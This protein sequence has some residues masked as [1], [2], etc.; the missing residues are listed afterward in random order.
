M[1]LWVYRKQQATVALLKHISVE[2]WVMAGMLIAVTVLYRLQL[3][4]DETRYVSVAWEMWQHHQWLLPTLNGAPYADK[5]PLL[6]WLINVAWGLF[7]VH[8]WVARMVIPLIGLIN[9]YLVR[10]IALFFWP[11]S[12]SY[13]VA[14]LILISM[15]GWALYLPMTMFDILLSACVLAHLLSWL[16][17]L[18]T[19]RLSWVIAAGLFGG[20]GILTK[21]PVMLLDSLVVFLCY[22]LWRMPDMPSVKRFY[23]AIFAAVLIAI[24][25][26]LAWAVPAAWIGGKGYA[27][28]IFVKQSFDR[29]HHSF[30]HARAWYWYLLMAPLI[31]FPWSMQWIQQ[32]WRAR[33]VAFNFKWRTLNWSGRLLFCWIVGHVVIF[34][35]IS[36]KQIHYLLPIFPAIALFISELFASK[37]S[38]ARPWLVSLSLLMFGVSLMVLP[39]LKLIPVPG[40]AHFNIIWA[41][42]PIGLA[43]SLLITQANHSRL[44]ALCSSSAVMM[45]SLMLVGQPVFKHNY[46]LRPIAGYVRAVQSRHQLVAFWGKYPD[47][48]QFY[49]RLDSP[50]ILLS[51]MPLQQRKNWAAK[52]PD[53]SV[54]EVVHHCQ[55]L[56]EHCW[57]YRTGY[58]NALKASDWIKL[59]RVD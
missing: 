51:H 50:L 44:I 15:L 23:K 56:A 43:I 31:F 22:P 33:R 38:M 13:R 4:V 35:L 16:Y 48:F 14:P 47:L 59:K 5:P 46:N 7:G 49:G 24:L 41:L 25:I 6:M 21:G 29:I 8:D 58:L 26:G 36:G 52:H 42:L 1:D 17:W 40:S 10:Q 27:E 54:I 37:N 32:L 39:Q 53:A 2:A 30:A 11:Q 18:K 57:P 9:F 20:L 3:P 12:K 34:S 19:P 28:A 55:P 45:I